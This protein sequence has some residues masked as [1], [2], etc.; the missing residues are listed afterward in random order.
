MT[1]KADPAVE[2]EPAFRLGT[3]ARE[4]GTV[5]AEAPDGQATRRV[6]GAMAAAPSV[7]RSA[8]AGAGAVTRARILDGLQ[9]SHGNAF[10]QRLVAQLHEGSAGPVAGARVPS[11]PALQR[12]ES[13]EK[14]KLSLL[15]PEVKLPMGPASL[16]ADTGS[17][18]LAVRQGRFLGQAGYEYG[19]DLK[20]GVGS[21]GP[22]S[23][24]RLGYSYSPESGNAFE[25]GLGY[26][27]G[28]FRSQLSYSYNPGRGSGFGLSAGY[29]APLAPMPGEV[30]R[31][32]HSG[33]AAA[34]G[35]LGA[36]PGALNDPLGTYSAQG[37][38]IESLK[39]AGG[40]LGKLGAAQGPGGLGFGAGGRLTYDPEKGWVVT[41]GVQGSF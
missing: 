21:T 26:R 1:A 22:G 18:Q 17:A 5:D 35:V 29:G 13:E 12:E 28:Q 36:L 32:A 34:R 37:E 33:E 11:A 15:P 31:A 20:L 27:Q 14:A 25:A 40:V 41:A 9:R 16:S 6:L 8:L 19:G 38:N 3:G 39:K 24:G 30:G 10:V 2:R 4:H 7:A 23:T